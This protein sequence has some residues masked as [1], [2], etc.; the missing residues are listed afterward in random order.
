M[1]EFSSESVW[2]WA[3]FLQKGLI[4][5]SIFLM[6]IGLFK[7]SISF[8]LSFCIFWLTIDSFINLGWI[9]QHESFTVF[10]SYPLNGCRNC[11]YYVPNMSDL[12]LLSFCFSQSCYR[13][14][15]FFSKKQFFVSL[16]FFTIFW[17]QYHLFLLLSLLLYSLPALQLFYS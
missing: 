2:A 13:F 4:I 11:S 5:N 16:I 10:L 1:V 12:C 9:Y 6:V 15:N 8:W 7:W 17:F 3:F 14:I